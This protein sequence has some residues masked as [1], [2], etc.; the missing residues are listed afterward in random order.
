MKETSREK[1]QITKKNPFWLP[2]AFASNV[3]V[4]KHW[5]NI[6]HVASNVDGKDA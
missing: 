1:K 5:C 4:R 6:H 2:A 3:D